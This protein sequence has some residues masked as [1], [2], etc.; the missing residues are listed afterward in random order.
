MSC[1]K[2]HIPIK[3]QLYENRYLDH[4]HLS[5]PIIEQCAEHD[6]KKKDMLKYVLL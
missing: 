4:Q 3:S 5:H 6:Q 1:Q 2:Y